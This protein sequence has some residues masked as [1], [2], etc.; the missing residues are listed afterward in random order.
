MNRQ[1]YCIFCFFRFNYFNAIFFFCFVSIK[2]TKMRYFCLWD[3]LPKI[4]SIL[5]MPFFSSKSRLDL[6][7]KRRKSLSFMVILSFDKLDLGIRFS[8]HCLTSFSLSKCS[9]Y[10]LLA[11]S[12]SSISFLPISLLVI[13]C[14]FSFNVSWN[15]L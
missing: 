15:K 12:L 10:V 3:Y 11:L 5:I 1:K 13:I 9:W 4:G 6:F 8:I 2:I 7:R 14:T